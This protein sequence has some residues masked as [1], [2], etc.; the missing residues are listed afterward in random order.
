M[1]AHHFVLTALVEP[2][3]GGAL[4][5]YDGCAKK[6]AYR[7]QMDWQPGDVAGEGGVCRPARE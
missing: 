2:Y 7:R 4:V 1:R 3:A 5:C 6:W